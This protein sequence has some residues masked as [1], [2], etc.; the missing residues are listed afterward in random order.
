MNWKTV[1]IDE[2]SKAVIGAAI[3]VHRHLGPG[4]LESTY[5]H[6]LAHELSL[7]GIPFE[8]QKSCSVNY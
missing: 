4:L 6:C 5:E 7:R 1:D 8:Q 3:E 2:I